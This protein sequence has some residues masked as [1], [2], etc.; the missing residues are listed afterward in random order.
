M[1]T[2]LS[3]VYGIDLSGLIFRRVCDGAIQIA[4]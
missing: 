1:M 2:F 4:S 3:E